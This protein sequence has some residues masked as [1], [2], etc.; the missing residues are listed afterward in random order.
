MLEACFIGNNIEGCDI[1]EKLCNDARKNISYFNYT[2][3]IYCCDIKELNKKYDA[4][5]IDLP[6]NLL[7][8][9]TEEDMSHIIESASKITDRLV[10]VS[11]SD[12]TTFITNAGFSISDHCSVS[13]RGNKKFTRRI[14][15]CE[16]IG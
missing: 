4:A 2:A 7:S 15:V 12:I 3:N 1:N 9:A 6:Y 10:I 14:W 8:F 5:I 16:K 11:I 13:K